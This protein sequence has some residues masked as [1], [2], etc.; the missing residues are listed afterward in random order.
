MNFLRAFGRYWYD[1]VVGDD[2]K[3]AVAV[4]LALASLLIILRNNLISGT[5]LVISGGALI[6]LFF[7]ISLFIDTRP[8]V[9][10]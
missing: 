5:W 8:R 4:L 7:S 9:N 1:F 6:M 2:W 10:K 3:I